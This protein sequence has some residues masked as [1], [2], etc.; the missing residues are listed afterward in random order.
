MF[1]ASSKI[2]A[3]LEVVVT[4]AATGEP[5]YYDKSELAEGNLD[6]VKA[7]CA[8]PGACRPYPVH[9]RP[10]FDGGV[11]DPVPYKRALA[12]GCDR[13]VLLLTRPA[14]YRRPAL[15]HQEVME[16]ALRRWP[17]SYAA[18]K[19]RSVR[20][21]RDVAAVKELEGEGKALLVAPESIGDMST[22]TR[23]REAIQHLYDLGYEAGERVLSFA[24][25]GA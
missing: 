20:Y 11:A 3:R 22:L 9:G 6:P 23:D 5:V 8:V 21:N 12:M 14:G 10:G 2:T 1:C 13:V 19:R 4:D 25:Q 7:S 24:R 17:N 15:E 16:K 18:L